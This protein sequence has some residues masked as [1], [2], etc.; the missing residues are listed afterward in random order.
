[1]AYPFPPM[2]LWTVRSP[3]QN[4]FQA[5]HIFFVIPT[6]PGRAPR[7]AERGPGALPAGS[8]GNRCGVKGGDN[9]HTGEER[10]LAL[11]EPCLRVSILRITSF[12]NAPADNG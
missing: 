8:G 11:L 9:T 10:C 12:A 3:R 7:A 6:W 5:V 2:L 4:L 1:M